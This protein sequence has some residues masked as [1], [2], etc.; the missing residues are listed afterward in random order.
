[1][2]QGN[3]HRLLDIHGARLERWPQAERHA[4][5]R[6]LAADTRARAARDEAG[7]LEA[8]LDRYAPPVDERTAARILQRLAA[9]P[10]QR[11]A[12]AGWG[13]SL[14]WEEFVPTW[15]SLA[16]FATIAVLGILVGLSSIDAS[17]LGSGEFDIS[18]LIL[19]SSP[20]IGLGQ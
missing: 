19:D 3:F 11:R 8:L 10:A 1:M 15:P 16:T 9:L 18:G 20:A 5:E 13:W 4:A 14:R 6:L 12:G 2:R 7:R 17:L